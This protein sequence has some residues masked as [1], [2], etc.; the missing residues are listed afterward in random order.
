MKF[1]KKGILTS[2]QDFGRQNFQSIGVSVGGVLDVLSFKVLNALLRND[3]NEACLEIHFP[4][5][6]ILFEE[7]CTFAVSGGDFEAY[8]NRKVLSRNKI[9]QSQ[10]GDVLTF[11]RKRVGERVYFGVMG[12]FDV[13]SWLG[14]SSTNFQMKINLLP[15][16]I[17]LKHSPNY[18]ILKFKSGVSFDYDFQNPRIRFVSDFEFENLTEKAK[19]ILTNTDFEVGLQSNRMGYRL[20]GQALD[21]VEKKEQIS[22]AVSKGTMQLLPNGQIIVLMADAQV[23][24]GYPKLGFVIEND[25]SFLSQL[26]PN[27][28][29]KFEKVSIEHA[30]EIKKQSSVSLEIIKKALK[31]SENAN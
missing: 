19:F 12:G 8:L 17:K 26:G 29:I 28:T 15:E 24:G 3:P 10:V 6:V 30:L 13:V 31:F 11:N 16:N 23:T 9:Y 18:S 21:L 27:K 20:K 1:I 25:L 14:S 4:G 22:S 5:P 2:V 7:I